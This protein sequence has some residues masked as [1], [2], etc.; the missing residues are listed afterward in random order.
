MAGNP[1]EVLVVRNLLHQRCEPPKDRPWRGG[2]NLLWKGVNVLL[3]GVNLLWKGVD[4]LLRGVNR[5]V[6]PLERAPGGGGAA[7]VQGTNKPCPISAT[8]ICSL[9]FRDWCPP[10]VYSLSPSAIGARYRYILSLSAIGARYRY[11]LSPRPR[12]VPVTGIFS[13]SVRDWCPLRPSA[14]GL[15]QPSLPANQSQQGTEHMPGV[16]TNHSKEQSICP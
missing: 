16:R 3:R 8:G 11:I 13:L 9:P 7:P 1:D 6:Q 2:M 12:L 5:C 10:Q 15:C 14:S 4:S